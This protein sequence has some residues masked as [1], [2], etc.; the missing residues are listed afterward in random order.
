MINNAIRLENAKDQSVVMD[1]NGITTTSLNSPNEVLRLISGGVFLSSDGGATWSTGISGNGINAN[2]ITSGR[3]DTNVINIMNNG[4]P[5]FKWD[6]AGIS[7]YEFSINENN[8][9]P[10]SFN[11]AKFVR[12]DRFG[13]YGING[14]S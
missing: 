14:I 13:I 10:T 2:Y 11:I 5:S 3:L 6:G 1:E 9:K 7:A 8:G 4:Q 12:F